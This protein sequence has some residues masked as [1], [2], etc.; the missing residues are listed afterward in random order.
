AGCDINGLDVGRVY[1][2]AA[3]RDLTLNP[4][5]VG[6]H[7]WTRIQFS[8][9]N[10]VIGPQLLTNPN[11]ARVPVRVHDRMSNGA[12]VET[13]QVS[14]LVRG[15]GLQVVLSGRCAGSCKGVRRVEHDISVND[16]NLQGA[17][18]VG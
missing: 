6:G 16:A 9:A 1:P 4:G 8:S 13:H 12:M 14:N 10:H 5:A 2:C 3:H 17:D 7:G 18:W 11:G 15:H